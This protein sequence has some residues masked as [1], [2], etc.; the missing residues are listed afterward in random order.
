MLTFGFLGKLFLFLVNF[1][2]AFFFF[3]LLFL[4]DS[5]H[6]LHAEVDFFFLLLDD[7]LGLRFG[8]G[9]LLFQRFLLLA[10]CGRLLFGLLQ[11]KCGGNYW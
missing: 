2:H 11:K 7:R 3:L 8:L 1:V 6:L 5:A 4:L 10:Q 9:P